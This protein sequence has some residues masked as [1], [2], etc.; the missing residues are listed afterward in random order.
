MVLREPAVHFDFIPPYAYLAWQRIHEIG[1]RQAIGIE[2]VPV[3]LAALLDA[4][5]QLGPA[6]IPAKRAYTFKHVLRL[7]HDQGVVLQPPPAHPF[8]PLLGLRIAGL[9]LEAPLRHR[10]ID[11]LYRAT[12]ESGLGITDPDVVTRILDAIGAP[13]GALVEQ[14][15]RT[16]SKAALRRRTDD[17]IARG[18]FGVPTMEVDGELFWGQD[19]LPHLER[20]LEGGDPV[21]ADWDRRWGALPA[22]AQRRRVR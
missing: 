18:V 16:E 2:P 12:W 11:A 7:A 8:N 9:S 19:A 13:G 4:H 5:G 20:F 3:S 1:K 21:P 6:E 10:V 17:A 14:A 15:Q 22:Q